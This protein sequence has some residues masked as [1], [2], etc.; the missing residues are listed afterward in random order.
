[1]NRRRGF[2]TTDCFLLFL[3]C[4]VAAIVFGSLKMPVMSVI[5]G[6]VG[7]LA[8]IAHLRGMG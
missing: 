4:F 6:V 7:V 1:M 5:F 2:M 8:G 3:I